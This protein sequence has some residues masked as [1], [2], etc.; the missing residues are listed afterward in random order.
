MRQALAHLFADLFS[1]ILFVT[2]YAI[3]GDVVLTTAIAVGAG[4]A[5]MAYQKLRGRPVDAMEILSLVLVVVFG[6]LALVTHNGRFIMAKPSIIHFAIGAV[7][8]RRGWMDR[9]LPAVAHD[10][11][12]SW[13]IVGAGYG[14]AAL[15]FGL[16]LANLAVAAWCDRQTWT[17]YITIVPLTAKF[18]AFGL[19][20]LVFRYLIVRQLRR[21]RP[22]LAAV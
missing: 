15:M 11:L 9:Y 18:A 8:L 22:A 2:L 16:G 19:Q 17:L 10:N 7:M 6:G 1:T 12:P 3:T 4:I 21:Q 20:Y 13:I 14:W 5:Q